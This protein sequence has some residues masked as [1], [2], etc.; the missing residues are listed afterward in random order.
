MVMKY[1]Q[2]TGLIV[3]LL[4]IEIFKNIVVLPALGFIA[5]TVVNVNDILK[6][7]IRLF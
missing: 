2:D 5:R 4:F 7:N 3:G 6:L 1:N